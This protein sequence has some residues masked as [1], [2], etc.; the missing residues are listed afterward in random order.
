MATDVST[1]GFKES[2]KQATITIQLIRNFHRDHIDKDNVI[3]DNLQ[4]NDPN[5]IQALTWLPAN[6]RPVK[7]THY[8]WTKTEM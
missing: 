6:T 8:P 7:V 2:A 3:S 5:G 1:Y 4:Q